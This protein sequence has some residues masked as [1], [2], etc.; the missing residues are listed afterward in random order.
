MAGGSAEWFRRVA[1]RQVVLPCYSRRSFCSAGVSCLAPPVVSLSQCGIANTH[2]AP[3]ASAARL[4]PPLGNFPN[5]VEAVVPAFLDAL[6]HL[7]GDVSECSMGKF[8]A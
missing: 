7:A 1:L 8:E 4:Y 5:P 3:P 2:A 6:P